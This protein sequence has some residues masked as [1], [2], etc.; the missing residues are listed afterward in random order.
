MLGE[1]S[2]AERSIVCQ[3]QVQTES[4]SRSVVGKD[5]EG[6]WWLSGDNVVTPTSAPLQDGVW[7]IREPDI[8]PPAIGE[9]MI[10]LANPALEHDHPLRAPGG[11]KISSPVVDFSQVL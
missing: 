11:G 9:R 6:K 1:S 5:R 7:E 8:W 2:T 3:W 10:L 4:G